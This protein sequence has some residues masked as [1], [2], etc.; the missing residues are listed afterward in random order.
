M[1]NTIA[2]I[3][4]G[5]LATGCAGTGYRVTPRVVESQSIHYELGAPTITS[6]ISDYSIAVVPVGADTDK[7]LVFDIAVINRG[8]GSANLGVENLTLLVNGVP[9][10]FYTHAELVAEAE[11]IR[12]AQIAAGIILG[13]AML[14]VAADAATTTNHGYVSTPYGTSTFAFQSYNPGIAY[15]AGSLAGNLTGQSIAQ[16]NLDMQNT[17]NGLG[18]SSLRTSTIEPGYSYGGRATA[19]RFVIDEEQTGYAQLTV[20][21]G[22]QQEMFEFDVEHGF[23]L[24]PRYNTGPKPRKGPES[25]ASQGEELLVLLTAEDA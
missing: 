7:R 23:G 2:V 22:D 18:S 10:E 14:Y 25:P 16:A 24:I 5:V 9:V 6:H 17:L 8:E 20:N 3:A 19:H 15:A 12:N 4:A 21:I 1:R 13:A 11:A